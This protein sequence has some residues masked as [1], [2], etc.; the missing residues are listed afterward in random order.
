VHTAAVV[1]GRATRGQRVVVGAPA[2]PM[3]FRPSVRDVKAQGVGKGQTNRA[4]GDDRRLGVRVPG[5]EVG[6][7]RGR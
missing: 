2:D 1:R 5:A 3:E 4:R 6:Q 7:R